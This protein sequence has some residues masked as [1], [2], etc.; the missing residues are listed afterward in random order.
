[1]VKLRQKRLS[2]EEKSVIIKENES[3]NTPKIRRTKMF[4]G[5]GVFA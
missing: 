2:E 1:M 5:F 3:N 4:S